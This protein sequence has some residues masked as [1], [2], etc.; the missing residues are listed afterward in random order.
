V[1]KRERKRD[2]QRTRKKE[3]KRQTDFSSLLLLSQAERGEKKG[4]TRG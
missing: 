4:K 3:K 2:K 1:T